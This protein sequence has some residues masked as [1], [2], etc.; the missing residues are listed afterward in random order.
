MKFVDYIND[1]G[2]CILPDGLKRIPRD[3]FSNCS[4]LK[5]LIIPEG[6]TKIGSSALSNCTSLRSIEIPSGVEE[7]ESFAFNNCSSLE[8][9]FIP[10]SVTEIGRAI[11][12]GCN[13]LE[14]ISISEE[15]EAYCSRNNC[16]LSKDGKRL[17]QGCKTSQIPDGV[18]EIEDYAFSEC[19]ELFNINIPASVKKLTADAFSL[20]TG[21]SKIG[22]SEKNKDYCSKN[23]CLLT[24][25]GKELVLGCKNSKIPQG[26]EKI[27]RAAFYGQSDITEITIPESVT[28]IGDWAYGYCF[29]ISEIEIP[30][31]VIKMG[32]NT[33]VGCWSVTKIHV[34]KDNPKYSSAG[35]CLLTKNMKALIFGCKKSIIPESVTKIGAWAFYGNDGLQTITIPDNT[36]EIC[37][38][39]F[40]GC[41]SLSEIRIPKNVRKI[42][43]FAFV[44]CGNVSKIEVAKENRYFR[45]EQNCLMTSDCKKII[46]GCNASV[47]PDG[48]ERISMHS[49]SYCEELSKIYIPESV[50]AISWMDFWN[51]PKLRSIEVSPKNK[52]YSSAGNCILSNKG[53]TLVHGCNASIIPD[54]VA[55]ISINAFTGCNDITEM[56]MPSSVKKIE[57]HAFSDCQNLEKVAINSCWTSV[58][59]S[60]IN[61][62]GL[63]YC[64]N[65]FM[66][67][68][69]FW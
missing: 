36:K 18:E 27:A 3:A 25:D 37:H 2:T 32:I 58:N 24:I 55:T 11:F 16:I 22:V 7:I 46:Q 14:N 66:S 33:F 21:L 40:G 23:N 53:R 42:S 47:I 69:E 10:S 54:G 61:C 19:R 59:D 15:N 6:V 20:C 62:K 13:G 45:S 41:R 4:K 17:I 48:V 5:I 38:S 30:K 12:N 63:P 44:G 34:A 65:A 39:A 52:K 67:D 8:R 26:V 29:G 60:F 64:D 1:D 31:S 57:L 49:F 68:D 28:E 56:D 50:K 51:C 43:V 9:I 35:N